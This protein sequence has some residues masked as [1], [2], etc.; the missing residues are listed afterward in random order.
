LS[1]IYTERQIKT[2]KLLACNVKAVKISLFSHN[3][4]SFHHNRFTAQLK[5]VDSHYCYMYLYV[6]ICITVSALPVRLCE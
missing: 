3:R 5:Q 1:E 2:Q 4:R 6:P